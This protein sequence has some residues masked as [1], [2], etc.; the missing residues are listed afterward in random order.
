[1]H[2]I[3]EAYSTAKRV[4]IRSLEMSR[5]SLLDEKEY[6]PVNGRILYE[7]VSDTYGLVIHFIYD[8][9]LNLV[10]TAYPVRRVKKS[11]KRQDTEEGIGRL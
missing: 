1:M 2:S 9:D 3:K 5:K 6:V 8:F 11:G 4:S 10:E 7:G